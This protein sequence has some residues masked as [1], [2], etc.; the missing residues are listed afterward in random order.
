MPFQTT[1]LYLRSQFISSYYVHLLCR[2]A[3]QRSKH[4]N[5]DARPYDV[6][7]TT[8]GHYDHDDKAH[9]YYDNDYN[10]NNYLNHTKTYHTNTCQYRYIRYTLLYLFCTTMYFSNSRYSSVSYTNQNHSSFKNNRLLM[11]PS[12]DIF[13]FIFFCFTGDSLEGKPCN[14]QDYR[15]V[16]RDCNS[17]FR[18]DGSVWRQQNCA[19][20]LHWSQADKHCDWPNNAKCQGKNNIYCTLNKQVYQICCHLHKIFYLKNLAIAPIVIDMKC[21][22]FRASTIESDNFNT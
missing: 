3:Q 15:E 11:C 20:G 13:I 22:I 5:D 16:P 6:T 1:I 9:D 7:T 2:I 10:N 4:S 14:G 21:P 8:T 17:Y 18:C 19:P 12:L